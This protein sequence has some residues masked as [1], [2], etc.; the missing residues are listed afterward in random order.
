VGDT[1]RERYQI[2]LPA[3]GLTPVYDQG[4]VVIYARSQ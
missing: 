1:E 3:E 2:L 4:G